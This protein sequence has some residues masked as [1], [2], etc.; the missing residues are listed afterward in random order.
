MRIILCDFAKA[1]TSH[2]R[3]K[4]FAKRGRE[5]RVGEE[6]RREA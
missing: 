2:F 5:R 1:N 3:E 4:K 6:F